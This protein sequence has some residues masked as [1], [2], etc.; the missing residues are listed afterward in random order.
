[1]RLMIDGDADAL[2]TYVDD[3]GR[4]EPFV[5]AAG[6]LTGAESIVEPRIGS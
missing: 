2:L 1:M 6:A 5:A 3:C 4:S